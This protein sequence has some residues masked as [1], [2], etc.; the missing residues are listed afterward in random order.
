MGASGSQRDAMMMNEANFIGLN[1]VSKQK[2]DSSNIG[3]TGDEK[4]RMVRQQGR[5]R[6]STDRD[7]IGKS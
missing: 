1:D 2:R 7:L 4:V 6:N 3:L 5:S